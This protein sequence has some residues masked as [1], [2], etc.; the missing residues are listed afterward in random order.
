MNTAEKI[1]DF[2]RNLKVD[3]EAGEGVQV[4]NPFL[5]EEAMKFTGMFYQKFFRDQRPRKLILGINPGRFG[6]GITGIPFTDP[7]RL[8]EDCGIANPFQKKSELSSIFI[9]DMIAA[10]GGPKEFYGDYFVSALSPLGFTRNNVNLNYYDDPTLLRNIEPFIIRCIEQQIDILNPGDTA[11]C[12][13][14]GE[15]FKIFSKLNEKHR[16]FKS[17]L[18]LKHPRWVMQY[19]LKSKSDYI[20]E[21]V[22]TL[23]PTHGNGG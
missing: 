3:F 6:G 22:E 5:E 1:L 8:Q 10:Y 11:Y 18:P 2:Y 16:F 21:Y 12:I 9:Y 19:R 4:M 14:G 20:N 7:V 23:K 15:N 17:I 13:G